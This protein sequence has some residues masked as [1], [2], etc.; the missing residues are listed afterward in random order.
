[1]CVQQSLIPLKLSLVRDP[2]A[3]AGQGCVLALLNPGP[4]VPPACLAQLHFSLK[5]GCLSLEAIQ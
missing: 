5:H 3:A 4:D 1:M 2:A